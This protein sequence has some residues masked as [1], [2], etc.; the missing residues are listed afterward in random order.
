MTAQRRHRSW[1]LPGPRP[2]GR[3]IALVAAGA[4]TISLAACGG[5]SGPPVLTWYINPD[6][7]GQETIAAECTDQADGAYRIVTELLPRD[8]PEQRD[9][10]ARRLAANDSSIALMSL[11]PPFVPEFAEAGFLAPVP[12]DVAARVTDD[13]VESAEESATWKD[14]LVVVP[15]WA[16]TQLL[17]YRESMAEE[18]GLNMD[19][20]VTWDQLIEA[21]AELDQNLGVHGDRS[22]ALTVW[23]NALV[24][25]AGG[26]VLQNPEAAAEDVETG[27]DSAAGRAAAE[28]MAA[29]PR[30]GVAGPA[31]TTRDEPD[32]AD[33][34]EAGGAAFMVNWPFIWTAAQDAAEEGELE[35][36]VLDDIGWA[37][38][39]AVHDDEEARPP[40]GGI[41]IG[42]GAFTSH[43]EEAYEAADCIVQP[44]HQSEYFVSDGNPPAS[45]EA[46][47]DR[48]VR[49][50][51]PMAPLI[52]ESLEQGAPR[53]LTPYYN[54]IS[55]SLQRT[56]HPPGAID[57]DR[58]PAE[59]DDLI[60]AVLRK[61]ALL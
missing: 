3:S 53:P 47:N 24:T 18:A 52:A 51:F 32:T 34:F 29:I 46:Y 33:L 37:M 17:W 38:Y 40:F 26:E 55:Q 13:I 1:R 39:P 30:E 22:E 6:D 4:L 12:E 27:L 9:Q 49:E 56:W 45:L 23:I 58:T 54:E 10:L 15:F 35:Q 19:E 44:E 60:T 21:T 43:T 36:E 42:V 20:P 31:L 25:S 2:R 11:D 61:E 16:N 14:E 41:H 7:G 57:P 5:D 59:S 48:E 8:A 28:V 50:H